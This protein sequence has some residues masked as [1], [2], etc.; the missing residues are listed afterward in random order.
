M[1]NMINMHDHANQMRG[2]TNTM[3]MLYMLT[4]GE[5]DRGNMEIMDIKNFLTG[6]TTNRNARL[7]P[8]TFL[9]CTNDEEDYLWMH[10]IEEVA[11]GKYVAAVNDFRD[12]K[13]E[14]KKDQGVFFPY[15][16]GFWLLANVV[17]AIN[18]NDLD[19]LD[20]HA[21]LTKPTLEGLLGRGVT[22]EEYRRYWTLHPTFLN[23]R[24]P[25][26][27]PDY[28]EFLTANIAIDIPSVQVFN[29]ALAQILSQDINAGEDETEARAEKTAEDNVRQWRR[30]YGSRASQY[31]GSLFGSATSSSYGSTSSDQNASRYNPAYK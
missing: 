25:V 14:V 5:P 27:E 31:L 29:R 7:N 22:P 30:R 12:E 17:A 4:D 15:S 13:E 28:Q 11:I 23:Q 19:A 24:E 21:P 3:T 16:R 8:F 9:A 6:V 2:N 20:Q 10:E 26:F 1:L 18:P